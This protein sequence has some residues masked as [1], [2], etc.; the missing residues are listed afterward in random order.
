MSRAESDIEQKEPKR[1]TAAEWVSLLISSLLL[2]ALVGTIL[3]LWTQDSGRP[4]AFRVEKGQVRQVGQ[5]YYLPF[6]ITNE[7]D[8]TAANVLV[9]GRLAGLATQTA[10]DDQ[11]T[12]TT[13]DFIPAH[14]SA[15]GVFVYMVDP[16]EADIRV[17][18]Y[19]PP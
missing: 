18:S 19:Q 13:F 6:T 1:R 10:A 9:A 17:A 16:T 3:T 15:E 5:R 11:E 14:A 8:A 4:A 7:G 12:T 2:F